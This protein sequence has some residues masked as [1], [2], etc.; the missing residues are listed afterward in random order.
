MDKDEP[1]PENKF[2]SENPTKNGTH[3]CGQIC[4]YAATT[5]TLMFRSHLFTV[6][7]FGPYARLI[8]WDRRGSIV[9]CRFN[10][11]G[12]KKKDTQQSLILFKFYQRFAQLTDE[13]RGLDPN[14][15]CLD[16]NKDPR[17]AK[18]KKQF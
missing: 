1:I 4:V 14:I 15:T 17:V 7:V 10:Y 9:T 2:P 16:S 8:Q 5:M 12:G 11:T 13:Q 6:V 3:T 18:A